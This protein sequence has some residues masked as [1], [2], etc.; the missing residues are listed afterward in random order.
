MEKSFQGDEKIKAK[1]IKQLY[2]FSIPAEAFSLWN[3]V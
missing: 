3:Y 2:F 1:D